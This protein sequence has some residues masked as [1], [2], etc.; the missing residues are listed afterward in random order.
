[1]RAPLVILAGLIAISPATAETP[2]R[3]PTEAPAVKTLPLKGAAGA[4][5]CAAY[6]PGFVKIEGTGSCVKIGGALDVG[7]AASTRR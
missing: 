1:M 2:R 7:V 3:A 5:P 4:N 6:G